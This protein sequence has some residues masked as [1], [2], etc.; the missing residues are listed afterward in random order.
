[1]CRSNIAVRLSLFYEFWGF[2]GR[3]SRFLLLFRG[4]SLLFPL[5]LSFAITFCLPL[6][7]FENPPRP[8]TNTH[9]SPIE[10]LLITKTESFFVFHDR[11][12]S[13]PE[14]LGFC[15]RKLHCVVTVNCSF[16]CNKGKITTVIQDLTGLIVICARRLDI[17]IGNVPAIFRLIRRFV[18]V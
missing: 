16:L 10:T 14:I 15:C 18:K 7:I 2:L 6:S 9:L 12:V 13:S 8:S 17:S 1:M 5:I 4:F 11:I 3:S